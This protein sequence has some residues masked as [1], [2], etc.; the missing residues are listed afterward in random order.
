MINS[1]DY[2]KDIKKDKN[3]FLNAFKRVL[4]SGNLILGPQVDNFER[5]FKK[6][7]GTKYGVGVGNCT[8]AIFISLRALNI[9]TGD[10]VITAANTAIPTITA[11][12]NSGARPKF[13][14]VGS[15]YL[16]D[17]LK[18]EK[19]ITKKTKAIIPVHLYGQTCNMKEILKITKKYKIKII[20][21]CA[22][23]TGS[24]IQ[25]KK[26]GSFGDLGCFSF[27]PTKVLGAF[28]D[29]GFIT[30][31]NK[32]LYKKVRNLRYMGIETNKDSK[33]KY[34]NKYYAY[35]HGTNSRLDELQAAMLIIK[36]KKIKSS[37]NI[38]RNNANIYSK[39]LS[40]TD[41]ILPKKDYK[42]FDVFY[43]F[44]VRHRSRDKIIKILKSKG[45][46]LKITYPYPI[47]KMEAY[48]GYINQKK[49]HNTENFSKEIFSLPVYPGIT[50]KQIIKICDN[51][52]KLI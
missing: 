4:E 51:I 49:L 50:K 18:I 37:I 46:N 40:Q 21:D 12:V 31:N 8:D 44:V 35:Y 45:I 22:Q 47:H 23:S 13:A 48:K 33:Q 28:G 27:Y 41:L 5:Q 34:K 52:K 36:F 24:K 15:D 10:E 6:F 42:R 2:L 25:N 38:R 11:I 43:E 29:G 14:D 20:E 9:G 3:K 39:Y 26:S 32:N 16:I 30:T 7:I 1:F 19:L 17:P